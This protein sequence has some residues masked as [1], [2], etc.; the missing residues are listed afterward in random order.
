MFD[1]TGLH[2]ELTNSNASLVLFLNVHTKCFTQ[3]SGMHKGRAG[4]NRTP[5]FVGHWGKWVIHCSLDPHQG[6][7]GSSL[8]P[9]HEGLCGK[10]LV[11]YT[12][13]QTPFGGIAK[14]GLPQL[15]MCCLCHRHNQQ[16]CSF[17]TILL[18]SLLSQESL[19]Q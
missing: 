1:R 3:S 5:T 17:Q 15:S 4:G 8:D 19:V 10:L 7:Q 9:T 6:P 11:P 14:P 18:S 13:N 16:I 12:S 2:C